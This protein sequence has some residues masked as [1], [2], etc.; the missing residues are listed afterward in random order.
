MPSPL[1]ARNTVSVII[2]AYNAAAYL[3]A[4]LD[5]VLNQTRPP[6]QIIVVDDGSTDET[7]DVCQSFGSRITT[8]RQPNGG[9]ASARNTALRAATGEY[10]AL[11]DA[12]D[13]AAPDRF[14]KQVAALAA[15]PDAAACFSGHWVF[16]DARETGRYA[17]E[18]ARADSSAEAFAASLLVH[19]ITMMFRRS[20]ADGLQFPVGVTTGGDMLFTGLLRRRGPFVILPD[21]LYG[22]RRHPNQITARM[23]D[24][25]SLR[26][27]TAWLRSHAA[28]VWPDL[29]VDKWEAL[30]WQAL[31]DGLRGHYWAR[32]QPEFL[33][34]RA[35][36]REHWPAHLAKPAELELRWYPDAIW[37]LKNVVDQT[38]GRSRPSNA[39]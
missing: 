5:A 27:R 26:Q 2:P 20:A 36:L 9:E 17:G 33:Q 34:L 37:R 11:L 6:H 15:R 8:I 32:R 24:L 4:A 22:Y 25:E 35:T 28:E 23:T 18:S 12:D 14:E 19:P 38:I 1:L 31:A 13:L 39:R 16:T 29:D 7:P 3:A 30:A 10:V 21:V